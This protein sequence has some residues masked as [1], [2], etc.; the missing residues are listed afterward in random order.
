MPAPRARDASSGSQ[1]P[2]QSL[3]FI[4]T[5]PVITTIV[6]LHR[7]IPIHGTGTPRC[8]I[9]AGHS[10]ATALGQ[11][12]AGRQEELALLTRGMFQVIKGVVA[13]GKYVS[14]VMRSEFPF[15][16]G[17]RRVAA[18]H[19]VRNEIHHRYHPPPVHPLQQRTVL[20]QPPLRPL[21][22]IRIHIK[23]VGHSIRAAGYPLDRAR[24]VRR[25]P[26]MSRLRCVP[27]HAREPQVRHS[28]PSKSL[29]RR[30]IH[31]R[32]SAA[33]ILL[34]ASPFDASAREIAEVPHKKLVHDLTHNSS[35]ICC[36]SMIFPYASESISRYS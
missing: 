24:R 19:M 31:R 23:I 12:L 16:Q 15:R 36:D 3:G 34:P 18:R 20:L 2:G 33:A 35:C 4:R 11:K 27:Q 25:R 7:L 29:Q 32:K 26:G 1:Y 14:P 9:V 28:H 17:R 21:R 30:V 8:R 13:V 5:V 22:Q 6:E 10:S